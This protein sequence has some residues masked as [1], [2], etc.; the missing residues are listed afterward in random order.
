M[1]CTDKRASVLFQP[2]FHMCACQGCAALMKKCVQCRAPI[3]TVVS[4]EVCC[5]IEPVVNN[6]S[7]KQ[8]GGNRS[9][10]KEELLGAVGGA[11][12]SQAITEKNNLGASEYEKLCQQLQDIKEQTMCPVCLDR[13]KN[14]VFLC[15]HGACQLCA[16]RMTE[17]PIC[18]KPLEK[19]ILCF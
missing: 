15:G 3:E 9:K 13:L 11:P 6:L 12:P 10:E 2:C 5:G 4:F 17:C 16:D 19:R 8:S 7:E 1:V 18:R 14:M